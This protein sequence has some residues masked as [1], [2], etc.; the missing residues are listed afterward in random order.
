MRNKEP[1][2]PLWLLYLILFVGLLG[3]AFG[4]HLIVWMCRVYYGG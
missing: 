2:E 4:I 1:E 3:I